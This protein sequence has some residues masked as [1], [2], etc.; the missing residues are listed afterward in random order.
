MNGRK[1]L[2]ATAAAALTVNALIVVDALSFG[3]LVSPAEAKASGG[4]RSRRK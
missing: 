4:E 3:V 2:V 1:L